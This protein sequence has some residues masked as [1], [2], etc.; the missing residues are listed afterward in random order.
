MHLGCTTILTA[1]NA[2]CHPTP[3]LPL[4]V[5]PHIGSEALPYLHQ[6]CHLLLPSPRCTQATPTAD[7][8]MF[9]FY[10]NELHFTPEFLGRVRL[11]GSFASLAGGCVGAWMGG[12][13]GGWVSGARWGAGSALHH[14]SRHDHICNAHM[15]RVTGSCTCTP[16]CC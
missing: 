5:T 15:M 4:C 11:A 14:T 6:H 16:M 9:Y 2:L 1:D 10:T 13:A 12:W 8:A 3:L 7:T